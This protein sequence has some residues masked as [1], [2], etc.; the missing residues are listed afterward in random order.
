MTYTSSFKEWLDKAEKWLMEHGDE[1][2]KIDA[3]AFGI[4]L[5][6]AKMNEMPT[7]DVQE[8]RHGHWI[9]YCDGKSYYCSNCNRLRSKKYKYCPHCGARMDKGVKE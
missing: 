7:A 2:S 1:I 6:V 3:T 8:V 5:D 4:L 9:K